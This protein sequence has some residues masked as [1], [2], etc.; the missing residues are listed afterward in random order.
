MRSKE[1]RDSAIVKKLLRHFKEQDEALQKKMAE[2]GLYRWGSAWVNETELKKLQADEKVI[3]DQIHQ[4]EQDFGSLQKRIR[5][6]NGRLP[7]IVNQMN[8]ID[9]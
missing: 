6:S 1:Q 9:A 4:M 7:D 2:S 5:D 8:I 3:K